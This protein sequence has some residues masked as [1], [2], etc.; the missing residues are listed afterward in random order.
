MNEQTQGLPAFNPVM[1][2]ARH[3]RVR[4]SNNAPMRRTLRGTFHLP[5][6]MWSMN[7]RPAENGGIQWQ[8]SKD[9]R[10]WGAWGPHREVMAA[11]R[12]FMDTLRIK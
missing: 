12:A 4:R 3:S 10:P 7:W 2:H 8:M 6:P 5:L 9:G 11:A 1:R